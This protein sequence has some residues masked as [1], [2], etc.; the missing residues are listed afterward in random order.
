MTQAQT[1]DL[2]Y[3]N[4]NGS[5]VEVSDDSN[6]NQCFDLALLWAYCNG[7]PKA[8]IAHLYA[9]Q[10]WTQATDLTRQYFDLIPNTPTGVPQ[11]G[12]MMIFDASPVNI[13][14]HVSIANGVGDINTFQSLDQNWVWQQRPTIITHNYDNPRVLGWLRVKQTP[15][16]P[17]PITDQSKYDFGQG[18]GVIELQAGRSALQDKTS[19]LN[20]IKNIVG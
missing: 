10:I 7:I 4:V 16:T 12:D 6:I 15:T 2:F 19:K 18:Y 3:A 8:A 5:H 1:F 11:K 9:K 14:G 13:A 20:Q 17:S